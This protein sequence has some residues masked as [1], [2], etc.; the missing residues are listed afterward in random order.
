[1]LSI[2]T[3]EFF[4]LSTVEYISNTIS[5][6]EL[7][8]QKKT[9]MKFIFQTLLISILIAATHQASLKRNFYEIEEQE[10]EMSIETVQKS[11]RK[12]RNASSRQTA[13]PAIFFGRSRDQLADQ[14]SN[15]V[16]SV[17]NF[18]SSRRQNGRDSR[19][20]FNRMARRNH[21]DFSK[22]LQ[23]GKFGQ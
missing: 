6:L 20:V 11:L 7:E 17:H 9:T 1:M 10:V 19:R 22:F 15:D 3:I 13:V 4:K 23:T 18:L 21:L 14:I 5:K 12:P 2:R 16:S 8:Q